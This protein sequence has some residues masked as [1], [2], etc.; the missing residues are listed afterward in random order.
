MTEIPRAASLVLLALLA[1]ACGQ[2]PST[3]S[4]AQAAA[5]NV[6]MPA[7]VSI[8]DVEVTASVVPTMQLGAAAARYR[9][10]AASDRVL[11]LV[12]ARRGDA[13][14]P[15]Q[16]TGRARDLRGVRQTLQFDT[17]DTGSG[18]EHVALA[19]VSGPD[20]LRIELDVTGP[21]GARTSLRF[22]R[23]IPR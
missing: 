17:V 12:A 6:A 15:V 4:N 3:P 19:R 16:V 11:V 7:L 22:N 1:S 20:T 2:S 13:D 5:R 9:V 10:D 23:D 18:I 21:D 8:G 14:V